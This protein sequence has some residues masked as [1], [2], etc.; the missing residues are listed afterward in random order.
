MKRIQLICF[1]IMITSLKCQ[2]VHTLTFEFV[3]GDCN[4]TTE[5]VLLLWQGADTLA[6]NIQNVDTSAIIQASPDTCDLRTVPTVFNKAS[7]T[8]W[9]KGFVFNRNQYGESEKAES[10]FYYVGSPFM[11]HDLLMRID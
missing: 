3:P 2:S 9:I 10:I 5:H 1:V 6:F 11:P 4:P 7:E 8:K